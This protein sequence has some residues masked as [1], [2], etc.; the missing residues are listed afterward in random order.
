[1]DWE[2]LMWLHHNSPMTGHP[3]P[4]RT[5]ELLTRSPHFTK[6]MKLARKIENYVKACIICALGK[7]MRQKPY[8]LLQ[9]L[10]I[11]SRPWQDIAMDFIVKLPPF[12][13]SSKPGNPEYNSI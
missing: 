12:K 8:G 4:K 6:S 2:Y 9:P 3:G 7:P 10:P 13:D 11:L 5:L 1:M